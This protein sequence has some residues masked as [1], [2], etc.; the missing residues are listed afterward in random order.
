M[1]KS[2]KFI[3]C[4]I[5]ADVVII[6][7]VFLLNLTGAV[8]AKSDR[9]DSSAEKTYAEN[10]TGD[11]SEETAKISEEP[12][13]DEQSTTS[14]EALTDIDETSSSAES[15]EDLFVV[16]NTSSKVYLRNEASTGGAILCEIPA[17]SHG[18]VISAGNTWSKVKY[19][20]QTGYVFTEYILTG[21]SANDYIN[22]VNSS[23]LIID[24]S[25]N[26]RRVPD[27]SEPVIGNAIAGTEYQYI[28][29]S[30]DE[31]WYAIILEDGSTA[32]IS[33]GYASL[34]N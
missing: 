18:T 7:I 23:R 8:S 27:T 17:N 31:Q 10:T 1:R 28:K 3:L 34:I 12:A 33:T 19:N 14:G 24:K 20:D 29:E 15:N 13:A 4:M 2:F 21:E 16:I 11:L 26:M 32:Y 5:S 9:A 25:C 22:N 6:S 30:S